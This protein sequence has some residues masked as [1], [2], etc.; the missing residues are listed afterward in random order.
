MTE[1]N[2][3]FIGK[4][5]E[6]ITEVIKGKTIREIKCDDSSFPNPNLLIIFT[7][8]SHLRLEYDWIYEWE[9]VNRIE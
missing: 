4:V 7:D 5:M 8:K 9:Y 2:E 3:D 1:F 6:E